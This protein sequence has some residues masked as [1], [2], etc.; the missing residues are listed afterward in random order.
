MLNIKDV[1]TYSRYMQV[2]VSGKKRK[3]ENDNGEVYSVDLILDIHTSLSSQTPAHTIHTKVNMKCDEDKLMCDS[4]ILYNMRHI[5]SD[6]HDMKIGIR[7]KSPTDNI[8]GYMFDVKAGRIVGNTSGNSVLMREL[9]W[10]RCLLFIVSIVL[11]GMY[12]TRV[13]AQGL[14]YHTRQIMILSSL[15][16]L[17]NDPL[18]ILNM[19]YPHDTGNV[20]ISVSEALYYSYIV[21]YWLVLYDVASRDIVHERLARLQPLLSLCEGVCVWCAV[22]SIVCTVRVRLYVHVHLSW[23]VVRVYEHSRGDGWSVGIREQ[24]SVRGASGVEHCARV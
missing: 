7:E 12:Y 1:S 3:I 4:S 5:P 22:C 24:Q 11:V 20:L 14:S 17:L 19:V 23:C 21:Y 6:I 16:I 10:M 8:I 9:L 2:R 18:S 13:R 15:Q